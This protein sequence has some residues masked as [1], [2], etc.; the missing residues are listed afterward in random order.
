[1]NGLAFVFPGQGSQSV[2]MGVQMAERFKSAA[3]VYQRADNRLGWKI[4]D[5]CR[6]GPAEKLNATEYAQPALFVDSMAALAVLEEKGIRASAV[7]GHSMGEYSA[8][9]ASGAVDFEAGL[10]LVAKRGEI[11]G[12]AAREKPGAMAAI[13]GLKDSEVEDICF[14]IEGVWPVNYNSPGQLVISG[15]AEAV[16]SAMETA[17]SAGA[18][19]VVELAV[20]GPFHS[21]LMNEAA[22]EMQQSLEAVSFK[23]PEPPFFS[24]VT[25]RSEPVVG[26][27]DLMATQMVSPVRWRQSVEKLIAA[28]INT[29]FEVGN[30]KVL[31]GLIKRIDKS[32]TAMNVSDPASLDTAMAAIGKAA[33][34]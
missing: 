13:L 26:L 23:E 30:G 17:K 2:G 5:L 4:S 9:A 27:A 22:V 20:S 14:G 24:S 10:D 31:S 32:V 1:M 21:P 28:E 12:R 34:S 3:A 25:C 33:A 18:K 19:K 16:R 15:E 7:L 6:S 29:F 8:L 11:M